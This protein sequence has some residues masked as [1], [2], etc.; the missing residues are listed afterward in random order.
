[1][2]KRGWCSHL[3]TA[4]IPAAKLALR[5]TLIRPCLFISFFCTTLQS[6]SLTLASFVQYRVP[7]C[8]IVQQCTLYSVYS[9]SSLHSVRKQ[10]A[11]GRSQDMT[12]G[13]NLLVHHLQHFVKTIFIQLGA[14]A[15]Q[16][17]VYAKMKSSRDLSWPSG[18]PRAGPCSP[19]K[20]RVPPASRASFSRWPNWPSGGDLF[21]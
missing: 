19:Q 6:S 17:P 3:L 15:L 7:L 12:F 11:E 4:A 5:E 9:K 8:S 20:S 1:M 2:E 21:S 10:S 13:S 18:S 14:V 16:W